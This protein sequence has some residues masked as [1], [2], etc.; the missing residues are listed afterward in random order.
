MLTRPATT[1]L[2][3]RV[4]SPSAPKAGDPATGAPRRNVDRMVH[5]TLGALTQ[6]LSPETIVGSYADW[7]IHLAMAPGKQVELAANA[8]RQSA[9]LALFNAN[10]ASGTA[11]PCIDPLPQDRRFEGPEWRGWPFNIIRESFLLGQ[12]WWQDATSGVKG[13]SRHHEQVA[14]FVTRQLVDMSSPSNFWP[15]NPELIR[16]T[17]EEGGA[18]LLCGA[19]YWWEDALRLRSG[20]PPEG[21]EQFR[22]GHEVAVT[23]GR[24][25]F[26][27]DLIELIQYA[28][29]TETV[30]ADPVLIVPSWI[31]K[32]YILDLS[33]GN[34]LVRYLVERGH[35]V[36][37]VSWKNP[38]SRDR[39][40]GMDDYL[41]L[42]V[43]AAVEAV[44]AIVPKRQVNTVGYCLG[45]TLLAI[46]AATLARDGDTRLGSMTLFASELDFT[47]P[48]ELS[49]FI[50]ES[51]LAYLEDIMWERGYLDGK[52]MAGAFALL[53]SRDLVWSRMVHDY[54]F[55]IRQPM[56]DLMAW[57]AD[58]TRMPC[59]QH[60]EY[61]R[62]LY[63]NNDLANG[64]YIVDGRPIALTDIRLPVFAVGAQRDTVSP[65]KSVYK[66]HLLTDTEV[67]FCLT[68][69]GH[70]VGVVNPP[71]PGVRRSHQLATRRADERYVDPDTWIASAPTVEGS[72]WPSWEQWLSAHA[73]KRGAP[74]SMGAPTA[75][76]PVLGEAPGQ[77]VLMP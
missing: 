11:E 28:P 4:Q 21:T 45:G 58:A 30:H 39:D 55:G 49:L 1:A 27:N 61:L 64:H 3:T 63:L 60:S 29:Q 10:A 22:P 23:P 31:M 54:L 44:T 69:G 41:K 5:A 51:Q 71:G 7:L 65:W 8:L 76:L 67:T 33:P 53:N 38:D 25:V 75:G 17:T 59:R 68:T 72:W 6:G 47:E 34:S 57:N 46:A 52:Q 14:T 24:V 37:I 13:V 15:T 26:R 19:K 77:Y 2:A 12:Q 36:F 32:Y 74:P 16:K 66:V 50:D 9:R 43:L 35:T 20:K 73:G 42:G 18:N 40:L 56:T 62:S 48:G 70:N